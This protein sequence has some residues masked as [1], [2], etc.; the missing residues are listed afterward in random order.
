MNNLLKFIALFAFTITLVGFNVDSVR[1]GSGHS[2]A[3][4]VK[5]TD[6]AAIAKG[7]KDLAIIVSNQEKVSEKILDQSWLEIPIEKYKVTARDSEMI[8]IDIPHALQP[9]T[10]QIRL[11]IYGRYLGAALTENDKK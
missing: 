4:P 9:Q 5:F 10:L 3:A 11:S 2:H 8:H 1:A 7:Q 6:Q